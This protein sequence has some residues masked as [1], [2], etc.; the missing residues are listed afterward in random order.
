M[1]T[2]TTRIDVDWRRYYSTARGAVYAGYRTT[3]VIC[4]HCGCTTNCHAM[5]CGTVRCIACEEC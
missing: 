1:T 4:E 5:H 2:N 3:Q